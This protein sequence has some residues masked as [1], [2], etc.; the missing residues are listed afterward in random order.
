MLEDLERLSQ[1]A[2]PAEKQSI[3]ISKYALA[4]DGGTRSLFEAQFYRETRLAEEKKNSNLLNITLDK[5]I[6]AIAK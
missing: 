2:E 5:L 3:F 1:P 6:K 4:D